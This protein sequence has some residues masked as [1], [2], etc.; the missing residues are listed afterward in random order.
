MAMQFGF[1]LNPELSTLQEIW[2]GIKNIMRSRE[3]SVASPQCD[4]Q[5]QQISR[6]I[7]V[8]KHLPYQ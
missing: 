4:R 1:P 3:M 5:K 2:Y 6:W 7:A 8:L